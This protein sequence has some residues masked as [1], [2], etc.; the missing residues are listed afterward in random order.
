MA[1]RVYKLF[2]SFLEY[3]SISN[4]VGF[5]YCLGT[6][7]LVIIP[8]DSLLAQTDCSEENGTITCEYLADDTFTVPAGVTTITVEAWGGGGGGGGVSSLLALGVA[9]RGGGGGAYVRSELSVTSG[10]SFP[11][12]VGA[13]GAGGPEGDFDGSAGGTSLFGSGPLVAAAGGSG[14]PSSAST[15]NNAAGGTEEDSEGDQ[16]FVGGNGEAG[17]GGGAGSTSNGGNATGATGGTGGS[18]GGGDGAN[19]PASGLVSSA[20]GNPGEEWGGGGSGARNGLASLGLS[21]A[22]G[23][24]GANG[25]VVVTYELPTTLYSRQTGNWGETD[26]WTYSDTHSGDPISVA[27]AADNTTIIGSNH[28]V[29]FTEGVTSN[30]WI[31]I[32]DT[33][34]LQT[35]SHVLSGSGDFTLEPGGTLGIGSSAGISSSGNT[36]N[37]QVSGNRSFSTEANYTYNGSQAQST[38]N[39]LPTTVN[40]FT[41]N[42][43]NGVT[44]LGDHII[45]GQLNLENGTFT[46]PPGSSLVVDNS[47][48]VSTNGEVQM[49]KTMDG[50]KG[51]RMVTSPVNTSYSDLFNGFVTQGFT[52]SDFANLQ[53][54]LLW[55]DETDAG[56]T[57]QGW[58]QP[59]NITNSVAGG[60][61]YFHYVFNGAERPDQSTN[62]SD[63]LPITLTATGLE[64][65][66]SGGT[67]S[68]DVSFTER[69]AGAP[70]QNEPWIDINEADEG[71]NLVG[72]PTTA[73]LDWDH[74]GWTKTNMDN[75]IYVWDPEANAGNGDYLVWDGTV[76]SLGDGLI[77]PFQSFWVRANNDNPVLAFSDDVKTTGGSFVGSSAAKSNDNWNGQNAT[78]E[79]KL[80]SGELSTKSFI[81]LKEQGRLGEDP[82]DAYRLK[83]M[84]DTWLALFTSSKDEAH[85]PL[86]INSVPSELEQEVSFPLYV[87]GA[88][89]GEPI[90]DTFTLKWKISQKW[91]EKVYPTLVDH[92]TK[93]NISMREGKEYTFKFQ[94][95]SSMAKSVVESSTEDKSK[96]EPQGELQPPEPITFSSPPVATGRMKENRESRFAIQLSL[97]SEISEYEPDEVTLHPNYPNPFIASTTISFS[98]PEPKEVHLEVFDLLGRKVVV[99][100]NNTFPEGTHEVEWDAGDQAS[101]IY[102]YRLVTDELMLTEKMLLLK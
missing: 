14:G 74:P 99:L 7:L 94:T 34:I 31:R 41:I 26:T 5:F 27:P 72:N 22:A 44:A 69:D 78:L 10:S 75:T 36:G 3:K 46:M 101:G 56:T 33:G 20:D 88:E 63:V 89:E 54:N 81:S 66:F 67:F 1:Q 55:F 48:I 45:D 25:R 51:W 2:H 21:P 13:G 71:W 28:T 12:V 50:S 29:S 80:E 83:P 30:E 53:S 40:N 82:G 98:L 18:Q 9:A 35:G 68:F 42:N 61:G 4:P 32:K 58:R 92:K 11:I 47:G 62:Y 77:A 52:G 57:L 8:K 100:T 37:I 64:Y 19:A 17:G 96:K 93:Q 90:D 65:S 16:I 6:T 24:D 86:V 76:G 38:G 102:L 87:G 84:N 23:G 79:L 49:Q 85:H 95:P 60:R 97:N 73:T 59:E 39:I 91:P 15:N 43:T 70:Q